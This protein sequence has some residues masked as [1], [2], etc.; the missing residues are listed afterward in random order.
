MAT[1]KAAKKVTK[2]ATT[3]ATIDFT[4]SVEKIKGT[5]KT[6]NNEVLTTATEVLEDLRNNG[7]KIREVATTRVNEAIDAVKNA[8][9]ENGVKYVKET[10]QNINKYGVETVEEVVDT[11]VGNT[12][13]WQGV[14]R[15][16]V[17]SGLE[18]HEKNQE[19][20]FETLGAVKDQLT[21]GAKRFRALFTNN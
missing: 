1:K 4:N 12:K 11:V 13:E 15:K 18:L 19:I 3:T 2:K 5:A 16:A 8:K 10:A 6:V 21:D 20:V 7:E 9:L 14:A 17:N